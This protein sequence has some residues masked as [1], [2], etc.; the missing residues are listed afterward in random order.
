MALFFYWKGDHHARISYEGTEG[1]RS[2]PEPAGAMT[3][4]WEKCS[5]TKG[6]NGRS[7]YITALAKQSQCHPWTQDL[8]REPGGS[9]THSKGKPAKCDPTPNKPPK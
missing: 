5:P 4:G 3:E 1:S 9:P 7:T 2:W 8:R 6:G